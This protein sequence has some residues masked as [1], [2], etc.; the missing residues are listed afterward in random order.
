M[1]YGWF[2]NKQINRSPNEP[3]PA[4]C[5]GWFKIKVEKRSRHPKLEYTSYGWLR[6]PNIL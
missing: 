4:I 3:Q 2:K 1:G 6:K 5:Y